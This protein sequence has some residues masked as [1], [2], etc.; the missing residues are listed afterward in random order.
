MTSFDMTFL[1][2]NQRETEFLSQKSH[3]ISMAWAKVGLSHHLYSRPHSG[4]REGYALEG[5]QSTVSK[6]KINKC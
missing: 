5:E 6:R 4:N 2:W 1:V 3:C